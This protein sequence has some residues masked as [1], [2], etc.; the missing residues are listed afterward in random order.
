ML[1]KLIGIA[2]LLWT[3]GGVSWQAAFQASLVSIGGF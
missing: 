2:L 1:R 3:V